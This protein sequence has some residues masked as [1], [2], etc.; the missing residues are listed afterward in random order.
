M[1]NLLFYQN[2]IWHSATIF[3]GCVG[4]HWTQC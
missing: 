3:C 4:K 1:I 2:K